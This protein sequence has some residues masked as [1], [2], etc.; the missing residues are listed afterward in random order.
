MFDTFCFAL[1]NF[2]GVFLDKFYIY[3]LL[4]DFFTSVVYVFLLLVNFNIVFVSLCHFPLDFFLSVFSMFFFI[5]FGLFY[6]LFFLALFFAL[7]SL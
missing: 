7:F 5:L 6:L 4:I 3:F 1:L 2:A